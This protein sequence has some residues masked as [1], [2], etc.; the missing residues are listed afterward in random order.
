MLK[1]M[2]HNNAEYEPNH[3]VLRRFKIIYKEGTTSGTYIT[4]LDYN[5]GTLPKAQSLITVLTLVDLRQD[6]WKKA[7]PDVK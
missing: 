3:A 2:W 1:E 7:F 6:V 5:D 4:P